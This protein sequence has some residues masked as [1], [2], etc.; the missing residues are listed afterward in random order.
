MKGKLLNSINTVESDPKNKKHLYNHNFE[1]D[2]SNNKVLSRS[3][4]LL[5]SKTYI[6]IF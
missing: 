6:N 3:E 1:L 5:H 4:Y 2:S